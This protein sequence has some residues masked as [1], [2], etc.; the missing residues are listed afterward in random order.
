MWDRGSIYAFGCMCLGFRCA[1][2]ADLLNGMKRENLKR[3]WSAN[4]VDLDIS[5][6]RKND[7]CQFEFNPVLR[8]G[9]L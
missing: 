7:L 8:R 4:L 5:I 9:R 2:C 6:Y 3:C 1:E